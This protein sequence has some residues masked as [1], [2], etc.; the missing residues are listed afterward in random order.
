MFDHKP[1]AVYHTVV[2]K[3]ISIS[4]YDHENEK[5]ELLHSGTLTVYLTCYDP[6]GRMEERSYDQACDAKTMIRTGILPSS[7]MPSV[8]LPDDKTALI[9]NPGTERTPTIIR[10]A[11]DVGD[12]L[13]I[14]NYTMGQRCKVQG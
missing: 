4:L 14:R 12:G 13:L 9:Y 1:Y 6:F 11:G 5:G 2:S 10:L 7:M 3:K 8:V